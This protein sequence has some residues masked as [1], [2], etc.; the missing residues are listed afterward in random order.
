M[1]PGGATRITLKYGGA[2]FGY[3]EVMAYVRDHIGEDY[4][5]L[6][7]DALAYPMLAEPSSKGLSAAYDTLFTYALEFQ[8][9][10]DYL[11]A[12]GGLPG[13]VSADGETQTYRCASRIPTRRMDIAVAKFKVQKNET[14]NLVIYALPGDESGAANLLKEMQRVMEFYTRR[15]GPSK[16]A[17]AYTV[18]E[19]PDGWGSQA[20]DF[21]ILQAAAAFKDPKRAHELYHEIGHSWN[22][23]PKREVQRTRWFDE[24][25][26]CYF[27]ALAQG[28]FAGR[29]AF[30]DSMAK[31]REHFRREAKEDPRNATTP[32]AE[33]GKEELGGNSY[34]KGPWSLYVLEQIVGEETFDGIMRAWLTEFADRPADFQDFQRVAERVARRD[35]SRYF[36]EWIFG[37]ESSELLAG[38]LTVEEMAA[39]YREAAPKN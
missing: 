21:Y 28:E 33:Y 4:T 8:A 36:N 17:T 39:R 23:M 30:D 2:I 12:C 20:S 1:A 18:I 5:L 25:F 16:K 26:A 27:E 10:R 38:K 14:G 13:S 22:A 19:I 15:F 11:L 31:N 9:P 29:Q 35:L 37:A 6:R 32:I 24:A 3:R 7:P 34:T